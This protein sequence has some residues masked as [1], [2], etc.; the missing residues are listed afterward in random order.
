MTMT[1][2]QEARQKIDELLAEAGWSV[3]DANA[4]NLY[5][6]R[7]VAVREFRLKPGHGFADYLLYVDHKAA[8]VVEA[9]PVGHTLT[10][11]ERQS[12]K[13]GTGLPDDLPAYLRPLPFL[14]QSTGV[15]TRFTN[16]LDPEPRSRAAFSF[17]R[18]E[19]LAEYI[20]STGGN[21]SNTGTRMIAEEHARYNVTPSLRNGLQR[22]P[23]LNEGRLWPVQVEA[24]QNLERSL[25][26]NRPRSL[27]QMATESGNTYMAC[28][29]LISA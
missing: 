2:E 12:E 15:E 14:Y 22:L 17:H 1:P 23:V 26:E 19:S 29:L 7:G 28:N 4:V 10:G 5:E 25:A 9:K 6:S 3:Q 16:G 18:L 21:H 24:I 8:G 27:V 20:G 13:Y 11:V